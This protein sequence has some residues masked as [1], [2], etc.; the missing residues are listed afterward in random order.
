[1]TRVNPAVVETGVSMHIYTLSTVTL[2]VSGQSRIS[3][4]VFSWNDYTFIFITAYNTLFL[5]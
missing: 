2:S 5:E 4:A 3:S 1:M